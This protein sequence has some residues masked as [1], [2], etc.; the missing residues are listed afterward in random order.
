MDGVLT[1]GRYLLHSLRPE[2]TASIDSTCASFAGVGAGLGR[3]R[4]EWKDRS[5]DGV[6]AKLR[7]E[8]EEGVRMDSLRRDEA[9]ARGDAWDVD[10]MA[11]AEDEV[12]AAFA[13]KRR[14][15][16]IVADGRGGRSVREMVGERPVRCCRRA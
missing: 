2:D 9:A 3:R 12:A 16:Y 15:V 10:A 14:E 4:V 13:D 11:E 1:F 5:E 8:A 6:G 7:A